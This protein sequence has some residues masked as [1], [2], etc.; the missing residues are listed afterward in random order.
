MVARGAAV[1]LI[2]VVS[3]VAVVIVVTAGS[4]SGPGYCHGW[5]VG[6]SQRRSLGHQCSQ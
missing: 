6:R 4:G 3:V 1:V 5:R 2:G